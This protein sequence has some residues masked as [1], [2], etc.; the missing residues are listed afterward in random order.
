[1]RRKLL[2][3]DLDAEACEGKPLVLDLFNFEPLTS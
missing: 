3:S 1:M 2:D